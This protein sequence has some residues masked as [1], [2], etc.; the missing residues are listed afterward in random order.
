[1]SLRCRPAPA[2]ELE[3]A[4]EVEIDEEAARRAG[5]PDTALLPGMVDGA[6]DPEDDAV[7]RDSAVT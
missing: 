7:M 6:R 1:M 5:N 4:P 3:C 2:D